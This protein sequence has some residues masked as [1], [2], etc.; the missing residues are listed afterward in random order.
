MSLPVFFFNLAASGIDVFIKSHI[1]AILGPS[2]AAPAGPE[3][4]PLLFPIL[5][6]AG[7]TSGLLLMRELDFQSVEDSVLSLWSSE[8]LTK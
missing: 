8:K 6:G 5:G 4:V 7:Q 1:G 2:F 3:G